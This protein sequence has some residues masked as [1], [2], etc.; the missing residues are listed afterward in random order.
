MKKYSFRLLCLL[1]MGI[2][3]IL[4]LGCASVEHQKRPSIRPKSGIWELVDSEG[5]AIRRI[6]ILVQDSGKIVTHSERESLK[7]RARPTTYDH[8]SRWD[9]GRLSFTYYPIAAD[10][11][12]DS[13]RFDLLAVSE[14]KLTGEATI[15]Q[16]Y[17]KSTTVPI[18]LRRIGL[19]KM[20]RL[21]MLSGSYIFNMMINNRDLLQRKSTF[22]ASARKDLEE[23]IKFEQVAYSASGGHWNDAYK[24]IKSVNISKISE[25]DVKKYMLEVYDEIIRMRTPLP[26]EWFE[27]Q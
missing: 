22:S 27:Q 6:V 1:T 16:S 13:Y 21:P 25:S 11:L 15:V 9:R 5:K 20:E 19:P 8:S 10:K 3:M 24:H 7:D 17:G 4:S 26:V 2:V 12:R 18:T 23:M 14:E